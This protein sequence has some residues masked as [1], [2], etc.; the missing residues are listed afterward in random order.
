M[1]KP[2]NAPSV[3]DLEIDDSPTYGDPDEYRL[4][5]PSSPC[6][7][8]RQVPKEHAEYQDTTSALTALAYYN[9]KHRTNYKLV[10]ALGSNCYY[11][12]GMWIHCNFTAKLDTPSEGNEDA[13]CSP[14]LF[15]A[16]LC[17]SSPFSW[18]VTAC[19]IIDGI[20]TRVDCGICETIIHPT[21]GFRNG[22][23]EYQP[24]KLRPRSR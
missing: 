12:N 6:Y 19:R 18:T 23:Y 14:K 8:E 1:K 4:E 11:G 16:E 9:K 20:K 7:P 21:R 2:R 22:L 5:D 24:R 10:D 3:V 17:T 13:I 15:F